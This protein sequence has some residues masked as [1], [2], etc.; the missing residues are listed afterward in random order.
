MIECYWKHKGGRQREKLLIWKTSNFTSMQLK[1][2]V[3]LN[4]GVG[5]SSVLDFKI[6]D[7]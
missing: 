7:P 4:S 1:S 6:A 5:R 3:Y 2:L